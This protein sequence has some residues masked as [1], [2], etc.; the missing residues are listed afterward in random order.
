M[1]IISLAPSLLKVRFH[2]R[3]QNFALVWHDFNVL[4]N[5]KIFFCESSHWEK[6]SITLSKKSLHLLLY[7]VQVLCF[8]VSLPVFL[9]YFCIWM[10]PHWISFFAIQ[11]QNLCKFLQKNCNWTFTFQYKCKRIASSYFRKNTKLLQHLANHLWFV[12]DIK[13]FLDLSFGHNFCFF[14]LIPWLLSTLNFSN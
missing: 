6:L 12:I 14:A 3:W 13:S 2:F 7:F 1:F 10:L 5:V 8:F 11:A 9:Q 4:I